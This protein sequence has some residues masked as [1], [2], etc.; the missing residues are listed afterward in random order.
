MLEGAWYAK[1]I[2]ITT[3]KIGGVNKKLM[4]D[5]DFSGDKVQVKDDTKC[6]T[7]LE[8]GQCVHDVFF[9]VSTHFPLRTDY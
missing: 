1:L 9:E 8:A 2:E 5:D 4:S 7:F 3:S 6:M